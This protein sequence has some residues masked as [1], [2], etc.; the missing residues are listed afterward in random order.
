MPLLL[1][2]DAHAPEQ[3]ARYFGGVLDELRRRGITRL[4]RYVKRTPI[5]VAIDKI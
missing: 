5:P 4:V 1:S 3:V 2:S